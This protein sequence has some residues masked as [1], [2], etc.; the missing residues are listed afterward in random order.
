MGRS[1]TL[2]VDLNA[3]FQSVWSFLSDPKNLHL[4]TVD[5][6]LSQPQLKSGDQFTVQTPRGPLDLFV[7]ADSESGVIDFHIGV[8]G[9]FRQTPSRLLRNGENNCIY[10]FT[11]FEPPDT[12][13]GLFEKLVDNVR[14]EFDILATRFRES[15]G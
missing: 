3:P 11:Q 13:P 12:P 1:Q 2:S 8:G 10:I 5:F 4:W 15:H 9:K 6:A 14:K 7:R